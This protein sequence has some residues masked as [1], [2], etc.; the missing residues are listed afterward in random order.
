MHGNVAEWCADRYD[1]GNSTMFIL[2][3][4]AFWDGAVRARCAAR[5]SSLAHFR[6]PAYGFRVVLTAE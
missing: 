2:R 6:G 3:G 4:G 1:P 5:H